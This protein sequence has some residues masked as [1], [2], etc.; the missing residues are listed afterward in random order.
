MNKNINAFQ[1]SGNEN[2]IMKQ[3]SSLQINSRQIRLN[4][5]NKIN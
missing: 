1:S 5:V 2:M 3:T 4:V